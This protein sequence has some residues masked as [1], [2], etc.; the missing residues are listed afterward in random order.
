MIRLYDEVLH[1]WLYIR[2]YI[3]WWAEHFMAFGITLHMIRHTT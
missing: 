3:V 1:E 2:M